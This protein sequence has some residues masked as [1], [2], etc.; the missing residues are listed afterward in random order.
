LARQVGTGGAS[1]ESGGWKVQG[2][3]EREK[4]WMWCVAWQEESGVSIHGRVAKTGAPM[5]E[6][7]MD[8]LIGRECGRKRRRP[9][10]RGAA[11]GFC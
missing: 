7:W 3:E 4:G 8:K 1:A 10:K 9:P 5:G 6:L 2:E 11:E